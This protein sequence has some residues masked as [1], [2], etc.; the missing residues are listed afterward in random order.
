MILL[1]RVYEGLM[2]DV[3][4]VNAKLVRRSEDMLLRLTGR[5]REEVRDALER[6]NGS[7]KVALM[8]LRGCELNEATSLLELA[9]G[10]LRAALALI[11]RRGSDAA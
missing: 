7:V 10:Q 11:G 8:L 3:Q 2:V 6:A 1:G 9:G 5:S 4:A